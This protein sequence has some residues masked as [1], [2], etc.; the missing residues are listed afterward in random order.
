MLTHHD[1]LH[2]G[3]LPGDFLHRQSEFESGAHPRDVGH[4]ATENFLGELFTVG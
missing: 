3:L 2:F 1:G 4:L